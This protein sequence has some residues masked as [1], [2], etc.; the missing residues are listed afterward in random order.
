MRNINDFRVDFIIGEFLAGFG[1]CEQRTY[2]QSEKPIF[3][4]L[5]D[6]SFSGR[7]QLQ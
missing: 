1:V 7:M 4:I 2:S 3:L 6:K 5:D